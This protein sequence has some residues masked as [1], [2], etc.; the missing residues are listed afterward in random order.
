M[1]VEEFNGV[2]LVCGLAAVAGKICGTK[3]IT[4]IRL[5]LTSIDQLSL[6]KFFSTPLGRRG[7]RKPQI[8]SV[9]D[10]HQAHRDAHT[11]DHRTIEA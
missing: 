2:G 7:C 8:L 11:T 3:T 10:T 5:G 1:C 6:P 9:S 4:T